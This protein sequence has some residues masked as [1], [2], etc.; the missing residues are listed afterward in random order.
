MW[1]SDSLLR[2]GVTVLDAKMADPVGAPP[3]QGDGRESES[4]TAREDSSASSPEKKDAV[5]ATAT[6]SVQPRAGT[7]DTFPGPPGERSDSAGQ[8]VDGTES[9]FHSSVLGKEVARDKCG[10]LEKETASSDLD[11]SSFSTRATPVTRRRSLET[12]PD[13]ESDASAYH[14]LLLSFPVRKWYAPPPSLSPF[15]LARAG[16]KCTNT[17]VIECPLCGAKWKWRQMVQHSQGN[18]ERAKRPR[19]SHDGERSESEEQSQVSLQHLERTGERATTLEGTP[20][21]ALHVTAGKELSSSSSSGQM[22]GGVRSEKDSSPGTPTESEDE[23]QVGEGLNNAVALS[24]LHADYC[25]RKGTFIPLCDV[26]LSG[27][28]VM[29]LTLIRKWERR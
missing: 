17:G 5:R 20:S 23:Q 10:A 28:S 2:Q 6:S 26:G 18:S 4:R 27:P 8:N 19:S 15:L 24:F 25:P 16:F 3:V 14:N 21:V 7:R 1:K 22:T 13:V 11:G 12:L 29:P 9:D